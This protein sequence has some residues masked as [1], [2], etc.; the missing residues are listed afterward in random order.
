[1]IDL[2]T[3][4]VVAVSPDTLLDVKRYVCETCYKG[5]IREQNLQLHGWTHN[6]PF[7]LRRNSSNET[8]KVYICPESTCIYHNPSHAIGDLGGLKKHYLRKHV[9]EKNH[10]CITCSKAYAV[11]VDLKAHLKICGKKKHTCSCGMKFKKY[12]FLS[13]LVNFL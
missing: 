1:M 13:S 2:V 8:K 12:N 4:H 7:I 10:K 9:T 11:E 3:S 5:F 6:L